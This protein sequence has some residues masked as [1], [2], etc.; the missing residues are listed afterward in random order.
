MTLLEFI[1]KKEN[2]LTYVQV[3]K[4]LAENRAKSKHFITIDLT[5]KIF[6]VKLAFVSAV[7]L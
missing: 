4:N 2:F 6:M 7:N 3:E 5:N 1:E